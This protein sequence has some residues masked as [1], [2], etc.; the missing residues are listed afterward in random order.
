MLDKTFPASNKEIRQPFPLKRVPGYRLCPASCRLTYERAPRTGQSPSN[1]PKLRTGGWDGWAAGFRFSTKARA[2]APGFPSPGP[3]P[4]PALL[5]PSVHHGKS[6][7]FCKGII[8]LP[9][10]NLDIWLSTELRG[11]ERL[12]N[13][14]FHAWRCIRIA[15]QSQEHWNRK[16]LELNWEWGKILSSGDKRDTHT[17]TRS[18]THTMDLSLMRVV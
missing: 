11:T 17:R 4:Q 15:I 3:L 18:H 9:V 14:P 7:T 12:A 13:H 5:V 6:V 2:Q 16:G 8:P 1:L 10:Q